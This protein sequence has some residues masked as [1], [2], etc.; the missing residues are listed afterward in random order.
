[1]D[2]MFLFFEENTIVDFMIRSKRFL[3]YLSSKKKKKM[4]CFNFYYCYI[5]LM[6]PCIYLGM[7][8]FLI[9]II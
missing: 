6:L 8:T 7:K 2:N 4:L 3:L 1:M 5:F 9:S